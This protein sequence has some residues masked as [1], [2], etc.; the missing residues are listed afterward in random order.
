[1]VLAIISLIWHQNY[2]QQKQIE[3]ER[4]V[5]S[6]KGTNQKCWWRSTAIEKHCCNPLQW[7][8][9]HDM[10]TTQLA[11]TFHF[12]FNSVQSSKYLFSFPSCIISHGSGTLQMSVLM[13]LHSYH[14]THCFASWS[15]SGAMAAPTLSKYDWCTQISTIW[16]KKKCFKY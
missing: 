5:S 12:Q 6:S 3:R 10:Y 7:L 11:T 9:S 2:K 14:T 8:E 15:T 16:K 4:L 1:M 13:F